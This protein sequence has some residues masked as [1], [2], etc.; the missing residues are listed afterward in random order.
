MKLFFL[1]NRKVTKKYR[2]YCKRTNVRYNYSNE[3]NNKWMI[4]KKYTEK[5]FENIKKIDDNGN[6]YWEARE[7]I[8][9]LEYEKWENFHKVIRKDNTM[10]EKLPI[11]KKSIKELENDVI[12]N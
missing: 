3:G 4:L 2:K 5:I 11:H 10:S 8:T 1:F 12:E 7:L 9:L 6:E